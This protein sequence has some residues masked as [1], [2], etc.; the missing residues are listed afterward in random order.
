MSALYFT[1]EMATI[2]RTKDIAAE[3]VSCCTKS[4]DKL[5]ERRIQLMLFFVQG[6]HL[7]ITG[8]PLTRREIMATKNGPYC[9]ELHRVLRKY[10]KRLAVNPYMTSLTPWQRTMVDIVCKELSGVTTEDLLQALHSTPP[11]APT[12]IVC[13]SGCY[14]LTTAELHDYFVNLFSYSSSSSSTPSFSMLSSSPE[15][16]KRRI[17]RYC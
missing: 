3:I 14:T 8:N 15:E 1:G 7:A 5:D 4:N 13:S 2:A 6:Y 11:N 10:R 16:I 9:E 12:P 17:A